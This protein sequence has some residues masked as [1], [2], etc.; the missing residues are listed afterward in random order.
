MGYSGILSH[1]DWIGLDW[2]TVIVVVM[3]VVDRFVKKCE[4]MFPGTVCS[5]S[6]VIVRY[7]I[8]LHIATGY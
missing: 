1:S 6:F 3:V 5:E 7:K 2:T 8:R 4:V